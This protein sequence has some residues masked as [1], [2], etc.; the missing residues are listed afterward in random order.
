MKWY[1]SWTKQINCLKIVIACLAK[2]QII[3]KITEVSQTID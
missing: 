2:H 1:E 3:M